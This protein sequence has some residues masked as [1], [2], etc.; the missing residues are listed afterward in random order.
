MSSMTLYRGILISL[1]PH[2][3]P[4]RS[5]CVFPITKRWQDATV[6]RDIRCIKIRSVAITI[7]DT[8]T[9][10]TSWNYEV[11]TYSSRCGWMITFLIP[12]EQD[13]DTAVHVGVIVNK[14]LDSKFVEEEGESMPII[15]YW[16]SSTTN[17]NSNNCLT[18]VV[19]SFSLFYRQPTSK[20]ATPLCS[21]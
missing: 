21:G 1:V 2:F 4:P 13:E 20:G 11:C 17:Q 16:S 7:K 19:S 14:L 18:S 10:L 15:S 12:I 5:H 3:L 6:T 9:L 8:E